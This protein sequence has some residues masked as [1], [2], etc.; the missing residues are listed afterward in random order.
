VV[1]S[2]AVEAVALVA[3][4]AA[5]FKEEALTTDREKCTRQL[6]QSVRKNVK[7]HSS[8]QKANQFSVRIVTSKRKM[9]KAETKALDQ[10]DKNNHRKMRV[11]VVRTILNHLNLTANKAL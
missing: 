11:Q 1:V 6:A 2:E 10:D 4:E 3:E 7:F 9:L 8:Q 5:D